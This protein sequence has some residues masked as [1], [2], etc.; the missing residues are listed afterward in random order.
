MSLKGKKVLVTG[1]GGFILGHLTEAG[2]EVTAFIRHNS[3]NDRGLLEEL[4]D[5]IRGGL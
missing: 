5:D 2:L 3:R 4:S 1:P